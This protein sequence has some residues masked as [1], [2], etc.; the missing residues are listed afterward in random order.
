[1]ATAAF[2]FSNVVGLLSS[3]GEE[4]SAHHALL[5]NDDRNA[6]GSESMMFGHHFQGHTHD[7]FVQTHAITFQDVVPTPRHLD[8]AGK[9]HQVVL[10]DQF[11]MG[12][13]R[14]SS[15]GF[16]GLIGIKV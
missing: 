6:H 4:P 3:T 9:V 11:Q 8:P 16:K 1:M 5:A 2:F 13:G 7:G 10:L 15:L 12:L 14:K